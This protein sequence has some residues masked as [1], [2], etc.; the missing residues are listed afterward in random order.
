ML[1]QQDALVEELSPGE[2]LLRLWERRLVR[3][4]KG[5]RID[6][7]WMVEEKLGAQR[8]DGGPSQEAG[9]PP[10]GRGIFNG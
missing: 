4:P 8:A 7:R 3:K 9:V 1:L 2:M 5:E 6:E 10:G